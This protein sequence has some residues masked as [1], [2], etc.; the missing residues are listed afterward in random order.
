MVSGQGMEA[1]CKHRRR[2]GPVLLIDPWRTALRSATVH[3]TGLTWPS[4]L[5]STLR[6]A[7]T[8]GRQGAIEDTRLDCLPTNQVERERGQT[9][10]SI[11][12]VYLPRMCYY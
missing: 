9:A 3:A 5:M 11:R 12:C 7:N 2:A 6:H 8:G 1:Q 4:T 10:G